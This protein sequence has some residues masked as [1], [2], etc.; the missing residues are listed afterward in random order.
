MCGSG[1]SG[2]TLID[3][4][5]IVNYAWWRYGLDDYSLM[6]ENVLPSIGTYLVD[7]D[8]DTITFFR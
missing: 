4:G 8:N 5:G 6:L 2:D 3:E 7:L 1:S